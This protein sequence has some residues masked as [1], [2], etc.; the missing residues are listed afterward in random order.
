MLAPARGSRV[1]EVPMFV[2]AVDAADVIMVMVASS[3]LRVIGVTSVRT[4]GRSR[5]GNQAYLGADLWVMV[6]LHDDGWGAFAPGLDSRSAGARPFNLLRP[7]VK[8]FL[9]AGTR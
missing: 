1:G 5:L 4:D 3:S 2:T 8:R 7:P 9:P 6:R